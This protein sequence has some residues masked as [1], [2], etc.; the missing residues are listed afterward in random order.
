MPL[1]CA[2]LECLFLALRP[3]RNSIFQF[4][5]YFDDDIVRE[6]IKTRI[7]IEKREVEFVQYAPMR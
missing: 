7:A 6:E 1:G 5:Y 4:E 2:S 3:I